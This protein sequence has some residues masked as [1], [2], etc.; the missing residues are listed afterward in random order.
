MRFVNPPSRIIA[1][2]LHDRSNEYIFSNIYGNDIISA[3]ANFRTRNRNVISLRDE[4][5]VIIVGNNILLH[6]CNVNIFN[7]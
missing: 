4:K 3:T 6:Q 2:T 1:F 5:N 7:L